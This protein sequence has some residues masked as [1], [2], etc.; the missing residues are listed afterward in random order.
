[1]ITVSSDKSGKRYRVR[2]SGNITN[3]I[4]LGIVEYIKE[5]VW[6]RRVASI[7]GFILLTV[8]VFMFFIPEFYYRRYSTPVLIAGFGLFFSSILASPRFF[9]Y[10]ADP[11]EM[12]EQKPSEEVQVAP[13]QKDPYTSL[14]FDT[15]RLS[16]YYKIN[17][18]Q[19]RGSFR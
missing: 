3:L 4:L 7:V 19:A 9:L 10:I 8:G 11:L 2:L 6:L 16:T 1:M 15:E 17:Q 5:K 14:D 18:V 12:P 13:D